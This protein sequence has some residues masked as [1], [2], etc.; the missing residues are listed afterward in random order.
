MKIIIPDTNSKE[1]RALLT[2]DGGDNGVLALRGYIT[3]ERMTQVALAAIRRTPALLQ[4]RVESLLEALTL[5]MEAGL[6]PDGRNAHLLAQGDAVR[7]VFDWKG[8]VALGRRCGVEAIHADVVCGQD[9]FGVGYDGGARLTH[10]VD[11]KNPR[12]E[13][14]AVYC[15]YI[16]EGD[17]DVEVMPLEEIERLRMAEVVTNP[18]N[19]ALSDLWEQDW[20]G[21]AK[22]LVVSRALLRWPAVPAALSFPSGLYAPSS[23]GRNDAPFY[24]PGD[25]NASQNGEAP[26][27]K[28]ATQ[29][30]PPEAKNAPKGLEALRHFMQARRISE[31]SMLDYLKEEGRI[32]DFITRLADVPE[33]VIEGVV[34]SWVDMMEEGEF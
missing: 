14:Y 29:A 32:A 10:E 1:F 17:P 3:P 30:P 25:G 15:Y 33:P 21:M 5:C 8:L 18:D 4:C 9:N 16:I 28:V 27:H 19:S 20:E 13:V 26:Q 2:S 34:S 7:V 24:E 31:E 23:V 12:G 11:Y 6:E 22:R